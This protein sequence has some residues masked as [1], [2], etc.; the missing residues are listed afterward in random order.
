MSKKD[1]D[2]IIKTFDAL[3]SKRYKDFQIWRSLDREHLFLYISHYKKT[4]GNADLVEVITRAYREKSMKRP[5]TAD[6]RNMGSYPVLNDGVFMGT[7]NFNWGKIMHEVMINEHKGSNAR[8]EKTHGLFD[9]NNRFLTISDL[10]KD[11]LDMCNGNSGIPE[12]IEAARIKYQLSHGDAEARCMSLFKSF[13][14][15]NII[16][17]T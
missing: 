5:G 2:A 8:P 1:T 17:L 6:K 12:I 7:F 13:Y 4:A 9:I 16:A 11:I 15:K 10:A 3:L 14:E